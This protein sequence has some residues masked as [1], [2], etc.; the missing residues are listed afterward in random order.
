[1]QPSSA[2]RSI[3]RMGGVSNERGTIVRVTLAYDPRGG[4]FGQLI[5]TLFAREP[6]IQARRD[7]GRFKQL[8][9][10]GEVFTSRPGVSVDSILQCRYCLDPPAIYCMVDLSA[11]R[12]HGSAN[13]YSIW[14]R[15]AIG[16]AAMQ[17]LLLQW[18]LPNE[19]PRCRWSMPAQCIRRNAFLR[20]SASD[21]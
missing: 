4:V 16:R 1:M 21:K 17:G 19:G 10:T 2:D 7:R 15:V 20:M 12:C 9:E 14:G 3:V 13:S 6:Q 5:A 11:A 18:S 8:T